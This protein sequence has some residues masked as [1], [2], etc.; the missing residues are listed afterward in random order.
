MT[1]LQDSINELWDNIIEDMTID[2]LN[3][4]ITFKTKAIRTGSITRHE[5]QFREV[6]AFYFVGNNGEQRFDLLP[7]ETGD[8][9]EITAIWHYPNGV[10][11]ISIAATAE[12]WAEQFYSN[13]NFSIE[14]WS[15]ILFIEA[16]KIVIDQEVFEIDYLS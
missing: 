3:H 10:G 1:R 16:K 7:R 2:V 12:E 9:L 14:I 5:L 6:S 8:F 13:A 15:A 4:T 11:K